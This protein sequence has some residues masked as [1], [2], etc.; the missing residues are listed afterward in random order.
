MT[1]LEDVIQNYEISDVRA[2]FYYLSRYLKQA[3]YFEEYEKDFFEDDY[4]SA[5]T[6][7]AKNLTYSQKIKHLTRPS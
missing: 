2:A 3:D 6:E 1:K 4:R 7:I 5:P